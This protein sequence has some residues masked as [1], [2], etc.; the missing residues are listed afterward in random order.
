MARAPFVVVMAAAAVVAIGAQ[1]PPPQVFRGGARTVPVYA[2][3]SDRASGFVLDL[4]RD[5][6]E[7][8]DNGKVQTITQFTTDAQPLSVLL[9]IDGSSS[10]LPV[11]NTVLEAANAFILRMLPEDRT[12]IASF[13]DVFQM[14]Q[15]FSSNRD[16]LLA[17]LADQF[18][19][20]MAGETRLWEALTDGVAALQAENGRRVVLVLTDGKQWAARP[21]GSTGP[22]QVL[23]LATGADAM[24]YALAMW[25]RGED[26]RPRPG[27]DVEDL[28]AETGGGFVELRESGEIG[29]TLTRVAAELH[30][31]Y[32]IGF[33]PQ[34]LDGKVH[35]LEVRVKRPGVT[36]RARRS[37]LAP[38]DKGRA[39]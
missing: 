18:N 39:G 8:K 10:M 24:V 7:V 25:T 26:G 21:G 31:Q 11:F 19:I 13:A 14:R 32:V 6:F 30:H 12:A 36:V 23:G 9:L 38:S 35:T 34:V 27:R 16:E 2:T 28:A 37:F 3:A 5:D 17:H 33:V 15:K 29:A 1:D 4:T 22:R 20:R